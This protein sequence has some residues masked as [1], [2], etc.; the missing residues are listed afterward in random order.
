M[1]KIYGRYSGRNLRTVISANY[2]VGNA[3]SRRFVHRKRHSQLVNS[4]ALRGEWRSVPTPGILLSAMRNAGEVV[5]DSRI[6]APIFGIFD[7]PRSEQSTLDGLAGHAKSAGVQILDSLPTV[8]VEPES[9][10]GLGKA[11]AQ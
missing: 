9:G 4:R 6:L 3:W 1:T 11:L 2:F 10:A 5:N 7:F 8:S